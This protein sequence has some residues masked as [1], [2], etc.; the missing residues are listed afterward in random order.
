MAESYISHVRWIA[1]HKQMEMVR[2]TGAHTVLEIGPGPGVVTYMLRK[3]GIK[4]NTLDIDPDVIA[5]FQGDVRNIH[6]IVPL[7][8]FDCVLAAQ[9]LEHIP[10]DDFVI[11]MEGIAKVTKCWCVISL[12]YAGITFI[13]SIRWGR[14][15][16]HDWKFGFRIPAFWRSRKI[17][18]KGEHKW[19]LGIRNYSL[20]SFRKILKRHFDIIAEDFHPLNKSQ[21]FYILRTNNIS[22]ND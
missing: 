16:F 19:E 8:S 11:A 13:P 10:W 3:L 15:R 1:Y 17:F 14:Y 21:V 7:D 9:V 18:F 12:P 20:K 6:K 5:D 4:V 22:K 2:S